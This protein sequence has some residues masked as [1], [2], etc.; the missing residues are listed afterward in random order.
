VWRGRARSACRALSAS[1]EDADEDLGV[2]LLSDIKQIFADTR[3]AF[4]AS[5]VLVRELRA[6]EESPWGDDPHQLTASKLARRLRAY[7]I[8]PGHNAAKTVRGYARDSFGD[9]WARYARPSRPAVQETGPE[10]RQRAS[11]NRQVKVSPGR[12]EASETDTPDGSGRLRTLCNAEENAAVHAGQDPCSG[13]SDGLDGGTG[14][15]ADRSLCECGA[16]LVEQESIRR[17]NCTRC[18]LHSKQQKG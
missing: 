14:A 9:V 11:E 1:A 15:D 2:L 13:R 3:E 5:N 7:R 16:E 8:A 17:G 18:F 4:L 10:Q 6:I 12:P